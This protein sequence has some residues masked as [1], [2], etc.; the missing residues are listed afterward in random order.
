M[1]VG[2]PDYITHFFTGEPISSEF[3]M[4]YVFVFM[5]LGFWSLN[6]S[7]IKVLGRTEKTKSQTFYV[8]LFSSIMAY[9]T[10]FMNWEFITSFGPIEIR[11]PTSL[12]PLS[13][14][15]LEVKHIGLIAILAACYFVHV[16][17]H[18]S[19]IHI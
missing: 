16:I 5:A 14:L 6:S 9:P 1:L 18:L 13:D 11:Y 17:T 2:K 4:Y 3:N 8:L 15:G 7:L 19:L 10:A 12:I